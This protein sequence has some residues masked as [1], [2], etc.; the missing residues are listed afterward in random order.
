MSVNCE[1]EIELK[2]RKTKI[3]KSTQTKPMTIV[4]TKWYKLYQ[5]GQSQTQKWDE[6]IPR[7]TII[8]NTKWDDMI[9]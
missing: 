8:V 1:S 9:P 3:K 6:M 5:D 4:D 7:R 2:S